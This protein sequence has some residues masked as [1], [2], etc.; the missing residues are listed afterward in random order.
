MTIS[1]QNFSVR[2]ILNEVRLIAIPPAGLSLDVLIDR[3]R[4]AEAGGATSLQLR[5]KHRA[6]AEILSAS[7]Q[8]LASLTIP[9]YVN[10]RADVAKLAGAAGAHVGSDDL[11]PASVRLVLPRPFRVGISVGSEAEARGALGADVDYWSIGPF[12]AT[13]TKSDAGQALG[14]SGFERIVSMAPMGMP[15]IA[16]GGLHAGNVA[17]AMRAG[18]QGIAVVNAVFGHRDVQTATR[19]LREAIDEASA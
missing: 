5:M 19:K 17:D 7:E 16:I 12:A 14:A 18:A 4:E 8:L 10:D 11:D 9:V 15:V 6:T 13:S 3:A 2:D 1:E